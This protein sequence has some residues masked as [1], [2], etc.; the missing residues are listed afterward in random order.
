MENLKH[1]VLIVDDQRIAVMEISNALRPD[2]TIYAAG[3]G[4]DALAAA[5]E[6]QPDVILLDIKMENMDG[7]EIITVLKK[8]EKTKEIPVIFVTGRTDAESE[9]KA[10][11]LGAADYIRKSFSPSVLKLRVLHQIKLSEMNET[12]TAPAE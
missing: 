7:F 10:F 8:S 4:P 6:H 9:E 5:E 12:I 1:S 2:C 11:A 3:N